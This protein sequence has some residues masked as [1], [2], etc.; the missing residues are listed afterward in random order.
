MIL[1]LHKTQLAPDLSRIELVGRLMMGNDSRQVEWNI[2]ELLVAGVKRVVFDLSKLEGIDSTGV[3]IIVVCH[4][5]LQRAGGSLRIAGARGIV[6]ETLQMTH[7]DKI[8][9]F[10]PS[11]EEAEQNFVAA[12][13]A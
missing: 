4:A 10:F 7:V 9:P 13:S 5:K 6:L 1:Q 12:Q 11:A 2:A 3:G 8:V